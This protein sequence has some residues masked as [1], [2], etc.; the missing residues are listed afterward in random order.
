MS[1]FSGPQG[2]GAMRAHRAEK[3]EA[4]KKRQAHPRNQPPPYMVTKVN[5]RY[6]HVVTEGT[7]YREPSQTFLAELFRAQQG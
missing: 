2:K 3:R 6:E 1:T 4:A 7:V 5:G